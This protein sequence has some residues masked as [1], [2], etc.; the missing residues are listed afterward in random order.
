MRTQETKGWRAGKVPGRLGDNPESPSALLWNY[1]QVHEGQA[2]FL[3]N[4]A[5]W[6]PNHTGAELLPGKDHF[7]PPTGLC[8]PVCGCEGPFLVSRVIITDQ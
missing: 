2:G 1:S 8:V 7:S 5:I 4:P 3:G 6:G